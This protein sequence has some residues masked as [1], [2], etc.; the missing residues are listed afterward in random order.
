MKG[1]ISP[2]PFMTSRIITSTNDKEQTTALDYSGD[3]RSEAL[4]ASTRFC[5]D[6]GIGSAPRDLTELGTSLCLPATDDPDAEMRVVRRGVATVFVVMVALLV[7]GLGMFIAAKVGPWVTPMGS[8]RI[9]I[10]AG[11]I[12]G[13]A[14]WVMM[15]SSVNLEHRIARRRI[16]ARGADKAPFPVS[17]SPIMFR[18]EDP[19][20]FKVVKLVIED[21]AIGWCDSSRRVMQLEGFAYRYVIWA[22]DI[23]S[24]NRLGD[25][26]VEVTFYVGGSDQFLALAVA[27]NG[28]G[29]ELKKQLSFGVAKRAVEAP[30]SRV[31]GLPVPWPAV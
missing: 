2:D 15:C 6:A 10:W 11:A 29:I 22:N 27:M 19:E 30:L 31:F 26:F 24:L 1:V 9:P 16:A 7:C 18:I 4:L 13:L 25:R 28:V 21:V 5:Q 3:F 17:E 14:G 23:L 12:P 20:T 8:F